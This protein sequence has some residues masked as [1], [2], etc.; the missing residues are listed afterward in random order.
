[1]EK[2]R[3]HF[4]YF[5]GVNK[6]KI[7]FYHYWS[8]TID[9]DNFILTKIGA[10][11]TQ[12]SYYIS[13]SSGDD[14]NPGTIDEPLKSLEKINE[15]FLFPGDSVLFKRGDRFDGHFV[16]NGSGE[17]G[18]P[19]LIMAYG[20]GEMPILTGQV[21]ESGG[22]DFQEA[23]LVENKDNLIFDG[24]E[25]QNERTHTRAGV[26][27]TDA[28]GM[29]VKNT[30]TKVMRNLIFRNMTFKNVFAVQPIL[31]REDFN[32]IQVSGLAFH[33][34]KN[35]E[36]GKEKN[37]D[38]IVVE[39]CYFAN[40]QRIGIKFS[41]SGGLTGIGNDSINRNMNIHIHNNEFYYN[42]G[43][44]VL[45]NGTYNC[46]IENNVF[47][48]PGASADPRMPGRGSSVW[49]INAINT[50]MQYNMCLSTRG[51][52]DS[53]GIHIDNHNVNTFVQYNYMEDC[54]G[55]F[56]EILRGNKNAVYRFNVS[57][58]DAWRKHET[59]TTSNHTIWVHAVRHKPEEFDLGDSIFIHNNTVVINK[60]FTSGVTETSVT[61]DGDN[62]YV[63]NNIFTSTNGG[64][65]LAGHFAVKK[66]E[67]GNYFYMSNNLFDGNIN[68]DFIDEDINPVRGNPKFSETG[69][70]E[71]AYQLSADSPAINKGIAIAGPIVKNA[72]Y[73]VFK[74]IAA[75]PTIDFYGNPI[76]LSTGT[77]NIGACNAKSGEV[78]TSTSEVE[79]EEKGSWLIYPNMGESKIHFVSQNTLSGKINISL[80]NL[81]GQVLLTEQKAMQVFDKAFDINLASTI[82]NGIYIVNIRGKDVFHSRRLVLFR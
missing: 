77:P 52:L 70:N 26:S 48:H 61:I 23:V 47:D 76:D 32:T 59:W 22:G 72:G 41:H 27:D 73:G 28:Y 63:Y 11:G 71:F 5:P 3:G 16:V 68:T 80:V 69:S 54:E 1:M 56:V 64:V 53:H 46:L 29:Y 2:V 82:P 34:S 24:L 33:S 43:T 79:L 12:T 17:E 36:A 81:K 42:G 10:P 18:K 15:F 35:T 57:V 6:I 14:N 66:E 55:G 30:G 31:D 4:S 62:T 49:N 19:I 9:L 8:G 7:G 51:Y 75:Y 44:S 78:S 45:P 20:E 65:E 40:I 67:V 38:G 21:G 58:N 50:I 25:I 60:P 37:I 39:D 74:E 13:S